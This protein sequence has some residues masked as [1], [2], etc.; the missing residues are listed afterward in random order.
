MGSPEGGEGDVFW[1]VEE[2][3][4]RRDDDGGES[5][6]LE[7]PG[8]VFASTWRC[9]LDVDEELGSR[10]VCFGGAGGVRGHVNKL[11]S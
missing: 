6:G 7:G 10:E 8:S 11:S 4:R 3:F 1:E 5:L 2:G 9:G